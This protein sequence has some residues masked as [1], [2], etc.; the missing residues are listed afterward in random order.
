MTSFEGDECE[1]EWRERKEEEKGEKKI[2]FELKA[3]K[4]N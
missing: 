4:E 2:G 1:E 3:K